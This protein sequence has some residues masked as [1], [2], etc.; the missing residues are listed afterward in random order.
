[1]DVDVPVTGLI[2]NDPRIPGLLSMRSQE[3]VS[4]QCPASPLTAEQPLHP[5]LAGRED[6]VDIPQAHPQDL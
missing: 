1:M 4:E 5:T 3:W 6:T 2:L